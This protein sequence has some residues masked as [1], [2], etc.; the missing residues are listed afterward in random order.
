M[1]TILIATDFSPAALNAADFAI[2]M[3]LAIDANLFVLNT[4]EVPFSYGEIPVAVDLQ[5]LQTS[6]EAVMKQLKQEL[7]QKTNRKLIIT[8]EVKVG[9]FYEGLKNVCESLMPY[10]IIMGS[11]GTSATE[12]LLFGSHATHTV[13]NLQWPVITVP[14][15]ARYSAIK[16]I[17]IACEIEKVLDTFPIE[18]IKKVVKDFN[19]ELHILNTGRTG[20]FN[21]DIVREAGVLRYLLEPVDIK[22]HFITGKD[23]NEG[24]L[25]F[26]ESNSIDLLIVLPKRHGFLD[27]LI[28]RS[29]TKQFVLHS[30]APVMALHHS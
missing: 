15:S 18:D 3:A 29:H 24:I 30:H 27:K 12:R 17:G 7:E 11:Q 16:K 10:A 1:K 14:A 28:H 20:E 5:E 4:V 9:G 25:D 6:A 21:P 13:E 2:N 8:T 19:A 26:A 22:F 23:S